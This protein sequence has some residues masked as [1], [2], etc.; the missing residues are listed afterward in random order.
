MTKLKYWTL[1][2]LD[3]TGD[4]KIKELDNA[5]SFF[6]D[7]FADLTNIDE[8]ADTVIQ[9]R[10]LELSRNADGQQSLLAQRC[11]LCFISWQIE[12][13]CLQLV[14]QFGDFHGFTSRNLLAYV[15][16]DDGKLQPSTSYQSFAREVL[17]TFNSEK[18]L[19]S[20]WTS[21]KVQQHKALNKF[22]LE[23]G[24]YL[25]SDWA[26]LNDTQPKQLPKIL[27]EFHSF[28]L[29]H[30][31]TLGEIEQAQKVL[32]AYHK[33]YR[34]ERWQQRAK[35]IRGKCN[36]P[37]IQQL[38]QMAEILEQRGIYRLSTNAVMRELQNLATKLR[39]YR[40][41]V[42][43]GLLPTESLDV[44][45][46]ENM[47]LIEQIPASDSGNILTDINDE[48]IFLKSYKQQILTCLDNALDEVTKLRVNKLQKKDID[49]ANKFL[50]ALQLFH[51]QRL[52]MS[53]IAKQLGLDAQFQ[54]TRLLKLKEFRADVQH[55]TL[56][57]LRA[58]VIQLAQEYSTPAR[59]VNL[60][61]QI[62][63]ALNEQITD[64]IYQAEIEAV[65]MQNHSQMSN[66]SE[67]LCRKLDDHF[68]NS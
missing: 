5:K 21:R 57:K 54:V 4:R 32:D 55:K 63:D 17:Q 14:R 51:C 2:T 1:V 59:L 29:G 47:T 8:V 50:M 23:C 22:L 19:L 18:S 13:A 39:Q 26:I 24:L 20:T 10:L 44:N 41:H 31:L 30:S 37:T 46:Y 15:L 36:T 40:I 49:K 68:I 33:I 3:G 34:A 6:A 16:D 65:S 28:T 61:K 35:G 64:L 66:F 48:E 25:V 52:S 45:L 11:L 42:R 9:Q 43:G 56:E 60:E 67:R 62:T 58:S 7:I 53:A 38:Q 27:S 12:Q